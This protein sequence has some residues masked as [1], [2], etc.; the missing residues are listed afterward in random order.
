MGATVGRGE[1]IAVLE[2][3]NDITERKGRKKNASNCW[4]VNKLR[5]RRGGGGAAPVPR[6]GQLARGDR[7]GGRCGDV[8]ILVRSK[9]AE[10]ILGYPVERWLSEATFW[11]II[12]PRIAS[13]PLIFA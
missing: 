12:D 1:S 8:Q 2:T 7:L 11:K 13:G 4:L 9:Q 5:S 10:R 6:S 3:N